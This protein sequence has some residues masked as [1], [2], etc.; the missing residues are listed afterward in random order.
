MTLEHQPV[1]KNPPRKATLGDAL[2]EAYERKAG[3]EVDPDAYLYRHRQPTQKLKN[4]RDAAV[5]ANQP[6]KLN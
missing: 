3:T 4:H 1:N 2:R 6:E 5:E